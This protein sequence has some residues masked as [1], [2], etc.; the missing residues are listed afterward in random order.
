MQAA[1]KVLSR[2]DRLSHQKSVQVLFGYILVHSPPKRTASQ[3]HWLNLQPHKK[4]NK[5]ADAG[6]KRKAGECCRFNGA[7]LLLLIPCFAFAIDRLTFS[8][9]D[10]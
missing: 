10:S 7:A 3:F 6:V 5:T 1:K 2:C 9:H 4:L 8:M